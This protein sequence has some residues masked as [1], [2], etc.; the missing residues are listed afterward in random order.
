LLAAER[1]GRLAAAI[2]LDPAY[3]D[4]AIKRWEAMTDKEAVHIES[5]LTFEK[6]R[7]LRLEAQAAAET[8][9][10]QAA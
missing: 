2:E 1:S 8:E 6:L 3:V 9:H 10:Q 5:G 4:V 7:V